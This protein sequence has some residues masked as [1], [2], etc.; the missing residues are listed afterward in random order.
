[1]NATIKSVLSTRAGYGLTVLRIIVG[2]IFI[3]HGSQK[4]FGAFGGYGL[5]GTAQ[6]M[7]SQ[8]LNPGYLMALLSGSVEFFGGLA[9][10]IGL[11]VRPAALG[12]SVLLLVAIF[13]VHIGNGLFMANNGYEFALALLGGSIAILI[14]GAG[15]LSADRA[16]AN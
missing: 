1:M 13:S 10:L 2:I 15:K 16:I 8:G 11:L 14:E 9:V 12:L 6:F 4:L 5:E 7:A 3:A